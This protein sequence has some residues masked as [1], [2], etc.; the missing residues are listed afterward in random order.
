[1]K[2]LGQARLLTHIFSGIVLIHDIK[3]PVRFAAWLQT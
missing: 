3:K 2:T 1:M